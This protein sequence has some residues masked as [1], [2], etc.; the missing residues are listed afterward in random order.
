[1]ID[2]EGP[3]QPDRFEP[4]E[5]AVTATLVE[6]GVHTWLRLCGQQDTDVFQVELD[7]FE[8]L[9]VTTGHD[10]G[11]GYGDVTIL[12]P[13]GVTTLAF[14]LDFGSGLTTSALA[15]TPGTYTVI[16]APYAV[17]DRLTYDLAL[18]VEGG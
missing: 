15:E 8:T 7:T 17:D 16:I 12:A 14:E 13:D 18:L 6:P 1:M 4:N 5:T 10:L 11:M 2:P 3:C 9:T